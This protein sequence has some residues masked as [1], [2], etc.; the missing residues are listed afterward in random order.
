M[1]SVSSDEDA[2][3]GEAEKCKRIIC[4]SRNET[5]KVSFNEFWVI[6]SRFREKSFISFEKIG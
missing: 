4:F 3:D 6:F 1:Q 2:E 5:G